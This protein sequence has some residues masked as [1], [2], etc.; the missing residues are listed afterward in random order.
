MPLLSGRL[1]TSDLHDTMADLAFQ[2]LPGAQGRWNRCILS[3]VFLGNDRGGSWNFG[4][5]RGAVV[6][7]NS[8][9]RVAH[10]PAL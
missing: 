8:R 1:P 2:E 9:M 5:H 3:E 7:A 4:I 10:E 6:L